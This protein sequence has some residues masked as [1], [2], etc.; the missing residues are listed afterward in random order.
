[1][2]SIGW[3]GIALK[4]LRLALR[5]FRDLGWA[6]PPRLYALESAAE[7][8]CVDP[9]RDYAHDPNTARDCMEIWSREANRHIELRR[10]VDHTRRVLP[11]L[12]GVLRVGSDGWMALMSA[13]L[14]A[15]CSEADLPEGAESGSLLTFDAVPA[16]D[17]VHNCET[18][19]AT[20]IRLA[21]PSASA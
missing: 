2:L 20:N 13:G 4:Q 5:Q 6:V 9:G 18:S 15:T 3:T 7:A 16:F 17:R 8:N 21:Q 1:L 10:D 11:N 14:R 12:R 19:R